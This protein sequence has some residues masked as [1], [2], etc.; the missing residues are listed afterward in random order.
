MVEDAGK[1]M[2]GYAALLNYRFQN[3]SVKAYPEAL[4]CVEVQVDGAVQP[5]EQ[6]AQACNAPGRDDQ[7]EIY[8]LE[9]DLLLPL[10]KAVQTAHPEYKIELKLQDESDPESAKYILATMPEVDDNRHDLLMD[11]VG[12]LSDG[13]DTLIQ[14]TFTAASAKIALKLVNASAEEMDEAK[15]ALQDTYDS[16]KD[17]C[18]QFREAKEQEIEDAYAEWKAKKEQQ[19]ARKQEDEAA[20]NAQAGMQMRFDQDDE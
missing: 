9:D 20:H 11:T 4:L 8:P 12:T 2:S 17:L 16:H 3:L 13:C 1:K 15:N 5:I 10:V 19:D 18:K 14:G 6:V 7:F